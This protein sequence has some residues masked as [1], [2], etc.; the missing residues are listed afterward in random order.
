MVTLDGNDLEA[1]LEQQFPDYFK[2]ERETNELLRRLYA[3]EIN[4][5]ISESDKLRVQE[6]TVS[7]EGT[8]GQGILVRG[9][10]ILT[11]THCVDWDGHGE[12]ALGEPYWEWVRTH[13]GVRFR[14]GVAACDPV[15]DMAALGS[16]DNQQF[17]DADDFGQWREQ[18][19]PLAVSRKILEPNESVTVLLLDHTGGWLRG[20]VTNYGPPL[21]PDVGTWHLTTREPIQGGTSGGPVVTRDGEIIGIISNSWTADSQPTPTTMPAPRLALPTWVL[22]RIDAKPEL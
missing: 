3:G 4:A 14:V 17:K 6:A 16:L 19:D 8:M 18:V 11:A 12:M 7:I 2:R 20:V 13:S 9:G 1:R 21:S 5:E 15:S 10:F 22:T